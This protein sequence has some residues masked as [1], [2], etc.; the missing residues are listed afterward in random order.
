MKRIAIIV[1]NEGKMRNFLPGVSKDMANFK[2]L[3]LSN[4]GG[5]WEDNEIICSKYWST[6]SLEK[7]ISGQKDLGVEY[8]LIIFS[9]HGYAV[10][11]ND[12]YLE[13]AEND[14]LALETLKKWLRFKKSLIIS[15]S[16]RKFID[17]IEKAHAESHLRMFADNRTIPRYRYRA[18]YDKELDELDT[19]HNTF[20]ASAN[21][22]ECAED[23]D[24]GGLYTKKLMELASSV[25]EH[26]SEGVYTIKDFHNIIS[27]NIANETRY[28][29]NPQIYSTSTIQSPPFIVKPRMF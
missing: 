25:A 16:C 2:K 26:G 28:R 3:L 23:T 21:L 1:G 5:A 7:E 24:E 14:D 6:V 18:L 19:F 17:L 20:I 13:I 27:S 9:G 10:K 4:A 11:N 29:Q 8:F 22:D 12:T 15:D